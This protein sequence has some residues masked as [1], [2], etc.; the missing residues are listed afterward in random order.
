[1]F[2]QRA[3]AFQN[4]MSHSEESAIPTY[5]STASYTA[6]EDQHL[7]LRGFDLR[8]KIDMGFALESRGNPHLPYTTD[9]EI[10]G[11]VILRFNADT[12][13]NDVSITL[14]GVATTYVETIAASP[15][16]GRTTTTRTFLEI[17]QPLDMDTFFNSGMAIC[18]HAYRIPF[19]FTVPG[20]LLPRTCTHSVENDT[21][22]A[23]HLEVPPSMGNMKLAGKSSKE[24]DDFAPHMATITYSIRARVAKYGTSGRPVQIGDGSVEVKILPFYEEKPPMHIQDSHPHYVLRKEKDV[25]MGL[26]KFGKVG[27]LTA[28]TIQPRSLRLLHQG[29]SSNVPV[30]TCSSTTVTLRF[31]PQSVKDQPPPLDL[32]V[33]KLCVYTFFAATPFHKIPLHHAQEDWPSRQGVYYEQIELSKR[34][35]SIVNWTRSTSGSTSELAIDESTVFYTTSILVPITLPAELCT[36]K[37][38]LPTFAS[39]TVSRSYDLTLNISYSPNRTNIFSPC[40]ELRLPLQICNDNSATSLNNFV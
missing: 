24:M 39:C 14:E 40:I 26:F 15:T 34:S 25:K 36:Q 30:V 33:A 27:R 3:T 31:D 16:L 32:V 38:F 22:R 11:S 21:V 23:A 6:G 18:A 19:N 4:N 1:M 5:E 10:R 28:E 20:R 37:M 2:V 8:K 7:S 13:V 17:S 29:T 9:D 35:L 12:F